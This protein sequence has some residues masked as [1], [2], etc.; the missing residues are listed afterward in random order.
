[1]NK[2]YK[3]NDHKLLAFETRG[4]LDDNFVLFVHQYYVDNVENFASGSPAKTDTGCTLAFTQSETYALIVTM[5][6]FM[7]EQGT[8]LYIQENHRLIE[9]LEKLSEEKNTEMNSDEIIED[10]KSWLN[11]ENNTDEINNE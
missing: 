1:M 2:Y 8:V 11:T 10:V 4:N 9:E 5:G 3:L 7:K 6:E